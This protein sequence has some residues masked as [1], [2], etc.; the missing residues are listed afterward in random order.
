M[1]IEYDE[2]VGTSA[3]TWE[4]VYQAF[5]ARLIEELAARE[6]TADEPTN[7]LFLVEKYSHTEPD[8][9]ICTS[10]R[11]HHKSHLDD[12]PDILAELENMIGVCAICGQGLT[13]AHD[14]KCPGPPPC[15]DDDGHT[16]CTACSGI[17]GNHAPGCPNS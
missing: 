13:T 3:L 17:T 7:D 4:Q 9:E 11:M 1:S 2:Y 16:Y 6:Q 15:T 5:K 10:C 12:C 14:H 8:P